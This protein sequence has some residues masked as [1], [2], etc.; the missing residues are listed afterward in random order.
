MLHEDFMQIM[1]HGWSLP[2]NQ[3]DKAKVLGYKFNNLRRV[4]RQWQGQISNLAKT[5]EDN[6][7]MI[8]FLDYLEEFMDLALEEWNFRLLVQQNL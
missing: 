6:K 7:L 8:S 4:L 5:I 3:S 1:E 2:N